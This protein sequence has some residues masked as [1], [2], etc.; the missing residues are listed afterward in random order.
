[1]RLTITAG[2][3]TYTNLFEVQFL[4]CNAAAATSIPYPTT[5]FQ[6][7]A[8]YSVVDIVPSIFGVT[9]CQSTTP[10]PTGL[11][12][13]PTT[14]AIT[15]TA[16]VAAPQTT[17]TISA[18]LNG[19]T[20]TGTVTM[21]FTECEGTMLRILRTY[22]S[23]ASTEGFRIRNTANDDILLE[24]MTG[25]TNPDN[26]DTVNYL[27]VTAERFDVTLYGTLAF[28][29]SESYIYVY[30]LLPGNTEELLL[31]ARYDANLALDITHYL[32]RHAIHAAEQWYYRMGEVP[33][34]W[35]G[36]DTTGWEQSSVG[37]F[38][39]S[40]NQIQLYKKT[41]TISSL[42][43]VSGVILSIRYRYGCIVY[44]N[45][46]ELWR[47]GVSGTLSTTTTAENVYSDLIY[48]VVT[49]PGRSMPT[50]SSETAISYLQQGSNT[51]AIAIVAVSTTT[52][53]ASLFDAT[54]RLMTSEPESHIWEFTSTESGITGTAAYAF[55]G[56][57][58]FYLTYT[59]CADNSMI[60]TLNNDRREWVSSVE[61]QNWYSANS[62]NVRQ[63]NLYGRNGDEEWTLL[64][65]VTDIT[66]SMAGQ[67]RRSYFT[68]NTPY[69]QFKFENFS[70]GDPNSCTWRVQSLNLFAD[71]ALAD[72]T[73]L[74]YEST[75]V[76]K[77]IEMSELIPSG[78]GY[79]DFTITPDLPT[80]L[81]IDSATGW[82]SGTAT[83]ESPMTTYQVTATKIVGGT[84]T[85]SF[86]LEVAVCTGGR[87]LMT[88]RFRA[89][90]FAD[91]NS[92]KLFQG[93]T[94][95]GTPLQSVSTFP[96]SN[97]YYYVDFC[98]DDNIYTIQIGD[99][100]GDGW[101]LN[102]GLTLTVDL[103][104]ME[105]DI[106]ELPSG[107]NGVPTY[108]SIAF[109]TF[110]PFQ[111][112]YTEWKV[113][114]G[115][116]DVA[117]DWN[118]VSFN[119]ATWSS[120]KAADIG[121]TSAITTYI[122]KSFTLNSISDYPVLNVRVKYAGGVA[123]YLNGNLVARFNLADGFDSNTESIAV[124]DA[125]AFSKF[126]VILATAG[127]QEGSNVFSFEIHRPLGG[128]SA[129]A[130]VF[131]ATG[132]FGVEDCSAVLDTYSVI[133][134]T[135][136]SDD[137]Y[138]MMNMDPYTTYTPSTN[139]GAF[140]EWTVENLLGSKW[141]S[142]NIV[143][144]S[145]VYNWGFDI[146]GYFASDTP[147]SER[148]TIYSNT[149]SIGDRIKPQISVPV[150]LASFMKYRWETIVS[151]AS[152]TAIGSLHMAYCKASGEVCPG[153]DNYP[154]VSEGQISPS[155][156]PEGYNGYAYR[157][158]SN[159]VLGEVQTD[160]CTHKLP[161]MVHYQSSSYTM[162][163]GTQSTTNVPLYQNI[164]TRWYVDTGVV[165]PSG[166]SLN[167]NTGEISG[168]PTAISEPTRYTIYAE[169]PTGAVSVIVTIVVRVGSCP[170]EG[171]FHAANVGEEVVYECSS[172]GNYVGTQRRKCVLGAVDGEWQKATGSCISVFVI[173]IVIVVV[174]VIIV[175]VVIVL[176]R[177]R[178]TKAVGGVKGKKNIKTVPKKSTD[179]KS[180]KSIKV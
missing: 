29:R 158:C 164:V 70:T 13:N 162:V 132:V 155:T 81:T 2:S 41:F 52:Q 107:T 92:W 152:V 148:I 120:V 19:E 89:D 6:Y 130:V 27:C 28:W 160:M 68:N 50:S 113:Y 117:S 51:I 69:N 42:D 61:I 139:V 16:S 25:H 17:Y 60:V 73:P 47:N 46:N 15:G 82:V 144:A 174:I 180:T 34:N 77:N 94:T 108:A 64:K 56:Y 32:R 58:G 129:D 157:E 11:S 121:T 54:V 67:R 136:I 131:D 78:S 147:V 14:C 101:A 44:L 153:I 99:T 104:E 86:T 110:F 62:Y 26:T 97:V 168:I 20:I 59:T 102:T 141:N 38:P 3:T 75:T 71:N 165:L 175:V 150:A 24:V 83:V 10:L 116:D 36:T 74:T 4:V 91:E 145:T 171:V 7:Y 5:D 112:E 76:F 105:L 154:S 146:Y 159:G 138:N 106:L 100:Y 173:V 142:F 123:A 119:D 140:L 84:T 98:L 21:T 33:A 111:I 109:S 169:N 40:T 172:Q 143:G 72:P 176:V 48:R 65:A 23:N 118:T 30:S 39:D 45:G 57:Y 90:G 125:T 134:A 96:V 127:I 8:H 63:F 161:T 137:L 79:Y 1:M 126:H 87:G 170:S 9:D 88:A 115:N 149:V 49:M 93:R 95:S 179:K 53:G 43:E 178:K 103:G 167:E 156:C 122:R 124:H 133:D 35:Y 37:S 18:Q 22:R 31:R 55:G 80:G 128:S 163:M 151:P 85:A 177:S 135:A 166:L 66:Y 12:V 114:Q